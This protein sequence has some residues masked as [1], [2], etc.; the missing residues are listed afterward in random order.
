MTASRPGKL[1]EEALAL[2]RRA[3]EQVRL[4]KLGSQS[5]PTG[6][7]AQR[8][9]HELQVHQIELQMQNAQLRQARDE[10]ETANIDLEAFNYTVAHDLRQHLATISGYCQVIRDLHGKDR[11]EDCQLF[12][13]E[14]YRGTLAMDRLIETLLAFSNAGNVTLRRQLVDLSALAEAVVAELILADP[15]SRGTFQINPGVLIEGDPDLLR[16]VLDNLLGNAWKHAGKG[17]GTIIEFGVTARD[18][19]RACFV[20]DNGPGFDMA[21]AG[22]LFLP[23]QRLPGTKVAGHGIGLATVHRIVVLHGGR[24]WTESEKGKGATFF[25]TCG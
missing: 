16:V 21:L 24:V 11:E 13:E 25:F 23:F 6:E 7:E 3:E 9:V 8:L 14:I 2:R 18:G 10:L 20:R 4:S 17:A 12:L 1:T 15:E 22:K 5:P 19:E